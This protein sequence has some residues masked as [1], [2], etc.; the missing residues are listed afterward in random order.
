MRTLPILAALV[1]AS[2]AMA[3][4]IEQ[5]T[6]SVGDRFTWRIS[7]G[8]AA[9]RTWSETVVEVLPGA[10]YRVRTEGEPTPRVLEFDGPGNLVQPP[11]WPSLKPM[12]F[13]ITVGKAW[14][15]AVA[16][17]EAQTRSIAYRAVSTETIRSAAGTLDCVRIEGNDVTTLSGV[18]AAAPVKLW[19]CPAARAVARKESRLP[20]VGVVT[21][22]L[23]S[24]RLA[25]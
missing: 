24:Y 3:Q 11:P 9:P 6:M 5:P 20:M 4:A 18:A 16:D 13:P 1:V 8:P 21:Q 2:G 17:T 7:G 22:E 23:V 25:H 12:Q 15:H 19:Y 14:T 10:R